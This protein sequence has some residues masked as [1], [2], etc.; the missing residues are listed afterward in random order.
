MRSPR[1]QTL[2][3]FWILFFLFSQSRFEDDLLA[4]EQADPEVQSLVRLVNEKRKKA[5]CPE[6]RWDDRLTAL[7]LDHSRDMGTRHFFSHT[8]PDGQD[9][10]DRLREA[11]LRFSAA[12]ENM[13]VGVRTGREVYALWLHS[14]DHRRNMLDCRFTRHGIGRDGDR[15]THVLFNP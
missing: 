13:A 15:W 3:I 8:N 4:S 5:G 1:S 14:P 10:F 7:A 6:L 2:I 12:A 11:H 9:P